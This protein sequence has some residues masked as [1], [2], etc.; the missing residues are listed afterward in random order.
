MRSAN[1]IPHF[2][3]LFRF[4]YEPAQQCHVLLYPEGMVKLNDSAA[5]ILKRVNG[6]RTVEQ[7]CL[8]LKEQF[9]QAEDIGSDVSD[10]LQEASIK[11][12]INYE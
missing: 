12:W 8:Q 7:I 9:P 1:L 3:P 6:E 5:E 11:R 10:F 4:Q 2:N